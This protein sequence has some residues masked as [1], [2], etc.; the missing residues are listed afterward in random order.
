M[1]ARRTSAKRD[2]I[3]YEE[4]VSWLRFERIESRITHAASRVLGPLILDYKQAR[5]L[6]IKLAQFADDAE[7]YKQGATR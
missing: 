5:V 3:G 2:V 6:S 7:A 4:G 1:T